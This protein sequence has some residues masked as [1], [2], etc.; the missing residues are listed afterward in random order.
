MVRRR[1]G[2]PR[3]DARRPPRRLARPARPLPGRPGRQADGQVAEGRAGPLIEAVGRDE[4]KARLLR[5]LPLVDRPRTQ[6]ASRGRR[7]GSPTEDDLLQPPHVDLLKGLA[8]CAGLEADRD[9]ARALAALALSAYRK[10]PGQGPQARRRSAT[11]PSRRSGMM[12][13]MDAVGQLALLKVKVKFGPAQKEIEKALTAAAEREGLPRD[14]IEELAVPAYGLDEVGRRRESLGDY[15]AELVVEGKTPSFAGQGRRRQAA[16]VGPGRRQEGARRGAQG[17]A[18]GGQGRRQDADRPARAASTACSSPARPGRSRLARAL[19]RPPARRHDRP[20]AD[21]A[22]RTDGKAARRHLARRPARRRRRPAARRAR[23]RAR[24][25]SSG[26]RSAGRS[27]RS[28]AW[29]DWLDRHQVR[30][31]FKQAHRE[32]YLLTDAE[33]GTAHLLQPLRRPRPAPAPVPRPLRRPRLA[34]QA[35][36][37]GRRRLPADEQD[38]PEWGLRAEFWVEGIGDEYGRDT[39][40]SGA[41][42]HLT[43]DQVRFY[44]IGAAAA[45]RPRRRRRL[46]AR[47][48]PGRRRAAAA[49]RVPPLVFSE[50]MRDVDLFVGVASVGNDPT[51]DDGGPDGRYATTGN[52]TAS[53]TSRPT[54]RRARPCSSG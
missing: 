35:P 46:L 47:L 3:G 42:L 19:P 48:E 32:V 27:T 26:T 9:L 39:T 24:R 22:L 16:Q 2:R 30:Q 51:W 53:A 1:A 37:D 5:W 18:S 31:P 17:A 8:W 45:L 44:E 20:P 10:V 41:Y 14:E 28:L 49:R 52:A 25:S 29:R 40:E 34:E 11:R 4:F 33:R 38:L 6:C 21:L 54:A 36:P 15:A 7:L 50:V 12:P 13:G 43:T 23:R